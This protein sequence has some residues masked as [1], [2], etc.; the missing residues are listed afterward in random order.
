MD[1]NFTTPRSSASTDGGVKP[2][3][4][5][6]ASSPSGTPSPA[7]TPVTSDTAAARSSLYRSLTGALRS[8]AQL[9]VAG[10]P[11]TRQAVSVVALLDSA[12]MALPDTTKFRDSGYRVRFQPDYVS[13]P[14]IGY[15]PDNYGRNVFG[16]TT[17]IMS[18]MLGNNRLAFSGEV[19][20]R[21]SEARL[22]MGYTNLANRW[23]WSTGASQVPYYFLAVDSIFRIPGTDQQRMEHQEI[24][25][26]VQ[27]Q[28]FG[29]T[30]YP[31]NRFTRFEIGAG[32][33]NIGR[34]RLFIRREINGSVAKQFERDSTR[35]E[36][37]LNYLDAQFAYVSDNTLF[38]YTGPVLGR[39]YRLQISPVI[40]SFN[41]IEYLADYRRYDPIIFNYLTVATRF[42]SSVSMG[43]NETEFPKYVARPDFVRGYDRN[44]AFNASCPVF[45][46]NTSNCSAVQLLGSRVMVANAEL[47]FPLVRQFELGLLPISLPP[48]DGLVFY[49]AGVAWSRGQSLSM[50]RPD[51]YDL[52]K[53]RYPLRSYGF[54]L[55]LNL[56]NYAIVRWDYAVPLDAPGRKGFWTW[57]LWPSF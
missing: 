28:A 53:Q 45:G 36:P 4:S 30:S 25:T 1:G 13:R 14:S 43:A 39:R 27:R 20:G 9:P 49:D 55:R 35:S 51:N 31:L 19:N 50:S 57:S 8:S 24:S 40:G 18:D 54:G 15:S 44:N 17:V 21:I 47:R 42:Y 7:S 5:L 52:T 3:A 48:L 11:T 32:F 2:L 29:V 38:G 10:E 37:T 16:G 41:W 34:Q 26:Y 33:N 6:G 23:Q 22:F 46:A 12:D 56:F